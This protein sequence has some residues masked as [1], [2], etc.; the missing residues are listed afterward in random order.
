MVFTSI[1]TSLSLCSKE[2]FLRG[3]VQGGSKRMAPLESDC[4]QSLELYFQIY[5]GQLLS[6]TFINMIISNDYF[7]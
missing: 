7:R 4:K 6:L 5:Q 2:A 3:Q 1:L